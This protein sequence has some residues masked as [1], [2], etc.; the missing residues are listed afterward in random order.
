MANCRIKIIFGYLRE[1][2]DTQKVSIFLIEYSCQL[3]SW[4][5]LEPA[6]LCNL[7]NS[8]VNPLWSKTNILKPHFTINMQT[9]TGKERCR[10]KILYIRDTEY[11][12][13]EFI[14]H[15]ARPTITQPVCVHKEGM[16][17]AQLAVLL[18]LPYGPSTATVRALYGNPYGT[19]M[20]TAE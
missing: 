8:V 4:L 13:G 10:K 1:T 7:C 20:A 15:W 9:F 19:S 11:L 5:L 16:D 3:L 18:Q 12:N 2:S 14:A 6:T 17:P